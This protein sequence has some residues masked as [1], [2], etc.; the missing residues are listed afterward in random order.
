MK[1]RDDEKGNPPDDFAALLER[2]QK[3]FRDL[4]HSLI[5]SVRIIQGDTADRRLQRVTAQLK[6]LAERLDLLIEM[7]RR[8]SIARASQEAEELNFGLVD[9]RAV[10]VTMAL[11]ENRTPSLNLICEDLLDR[12]IEATGAERGFILFYVPES[13]EADVVAARSFQTRNLSLEEYR[14]SRTLLREVLESG[15]SIIL[16]DA[17][18]DRVFSQE[19]SVINLR[20][21]SV[22]AVPL[23]Q[24][25][26]TIG[27]LYLENNSRACAFVER[28]LQLVE[29]VSLFTSAYL[30]SLRLLPITFE[31]DG[32][33]FLDESKAS[34]EIIG[35]DPKI[36]A[37][38][39]MVDRLA[40]SP[41]TVLI[42][43]E[44][45]TGKELVARA[46]HYQGARRDSPFVAINCAAIPD[47][48]LESE[49]FG[50]EK[51]AFTGATHAYIGRIEQGE[52]GT[53]FLDEISELAYSLQ[54]KLLRF[55]QSNEFDRLGGKRPVR[56]NVRVVAATSKDLKSLRV[57]RHFRDE[58]LT[59]RLVG[60][61]FIRGYERLA[62]SIADSVRGSVI[63][64][65]AV[66]LILAPIVVLC[67]LY[68]TLSTGKGARKRRR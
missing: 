47:N 58:C 55:L 10:E 50:H 45:G 49:L 13:T 36:L 29:S 57:L 2:E 40:D 43:G 23:K 54:A 30:D 22:L 24:A 67:R 15:V 25:S 18:E 56:V 53:I 1:T 17:S 8:E 34:K 11:V 19:A 44:S 33:L 9:R 5:E 41:A 51:G 65:G 62:P 7:A 12:L 42:Q 60:R 66:R 52:G 6:S 28:H 68:W 3:R 4:I 16:K 63:A 35:R 32:G 38:L 26:R 31:R 39:E 14:F 21:K 48:L 64:R 59:R 20:L 46:L 37:L 61:A 27:V